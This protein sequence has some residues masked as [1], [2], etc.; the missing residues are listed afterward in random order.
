MKSNIE[1]Y[2]NYSIFNVMLLIM[3]VSDTSSF[4]DFGENMFRLIDNKGDNLWN[5]VFISEWLYL[6]MSLS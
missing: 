5:K 2:Y 3:F 4:Y 1:L 6:N